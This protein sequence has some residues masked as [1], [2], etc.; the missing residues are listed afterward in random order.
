MYTYSY[1][2][3]GQHIV[4]IYS[5]LKIWALQISTEVGACTFD[6][7]VSCVWYHI[8][9]RIFC[10]VFVV[11]S[12]KMRDSYWYILLQVKK[13][14]QSVHISWVYAQQTVISNKMLLTIQ[15]K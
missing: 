14:R 9:L 13:L 4:R 10:L 5:I 6:K 8:F 12:L 7:T 15:E 11:L 3:V 2:G 1:T